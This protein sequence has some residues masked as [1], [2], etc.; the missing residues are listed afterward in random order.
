MTL[1]TVLGILISLAIVFWYALVTSNHHEDML[2]ATSKNIVIV[3]AIF[4][5]IIIALQ[6]LG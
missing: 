2:R 1:N 3:C 5:L 4:S 6:F